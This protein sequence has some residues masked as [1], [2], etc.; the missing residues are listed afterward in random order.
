HIT[1]ALQLFAEDKAVHTGQDEIDDG[2]MRQALLPD[3]VQRVRRIADS[4][5]VVASFFEDGPQDLLNSRI[6][7]HNEQSFILHIF[8]SWRTARIPS[9]LFAE[10]LLQCMVRLR[11]IATL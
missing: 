2:E 9:R 1:H 4:R 6:V 3:D 11:I 10:L 5:G 7:F 8:S